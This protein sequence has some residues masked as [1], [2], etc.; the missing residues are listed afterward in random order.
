ML[1][2]REAYLIGEGRDQHEPSHCEGRC[3]SL[4][5]NFTLVDITGREEWPGKRWV[6]T[7]CVSEADQKLVAAALS[8]S[9]GETE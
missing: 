5:P 8:I 3:R 4:R 1:P 9:E 2:T 7:A 6:C